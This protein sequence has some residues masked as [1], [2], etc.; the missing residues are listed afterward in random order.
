[1]NTNMIPVPSQTKRP[2]AS[3]PRTDSTTFLDQ[4]K[5][6]FVRMIYLHGHTH[7]HTHTLVEFSRAMDEYFKQVYKEFGHKH[8]VR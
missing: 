6:D 3:T 5:G 2:T 1:M 8:E 7:G 4:F